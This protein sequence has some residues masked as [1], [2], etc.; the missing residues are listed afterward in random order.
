MTRPSKWSPLLDLAGIEIPT[1]FRGRS[2][3]AALD[4]SELTPRPVVAELFPRAG[5]TP[6]HR[7][8]VANAAET[9]VMAADGQ[10]SRIATLA[11]SSRARP[12]A[13]SPADLSR[14]LGD[15]ETWIDFSERDP[16]DAIEVSDEMRERLRALGYAR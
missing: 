15:L 13:A 6:R 1:S 10:L 3:K 11:G 14:V 7:L 2:L 16:A 4:G 12:V 8:V 5:V 9:I